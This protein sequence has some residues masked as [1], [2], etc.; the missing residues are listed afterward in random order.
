MLIAARRRRS[1]TAL[2]L[3][4]GLTACGG[5]AGTPAAQT[6]TRDAAPAAAPSGATATAI[7]YQC[8]SGRRST[9]T[10]SIPDPRRLPEVVNPIQVCEYDGGL[11]SIEVAIACRP[12]P[13]PSPVRVLAV[14]G[15]LPASA[16]RVLCAS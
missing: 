1:V 10:V 11:A 8:R 9:I 15:K 4:T 6:P 5:G 2:C 12:G 16:G 3:L 14:D 13:P 7:S